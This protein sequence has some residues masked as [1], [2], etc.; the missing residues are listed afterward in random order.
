MWQPL[1]CDLKMSIAFH[2]QTD[3]QIELVKRI[4]S[5]MLQCLVKSASEWELVLSQFKFVCN[6]SVNKSTCL[7][8]FHIC[9]GYDAFT[10]LD[11]APFPPMS[12]VSASTMEFCQY[13]KVIREEN[14]KQVETIYASVKAHIDQH[15][16]I[17]NLQAGDLVL[18]YASQHTQ[19]KKL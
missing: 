17:Q 4:L 12:P 1:L 10:T 11:L 18:A 13:I 3:G 19:E 16:H 7:S 9:N 15:Q 2:Q 5:D 8:L 14:L 6:N